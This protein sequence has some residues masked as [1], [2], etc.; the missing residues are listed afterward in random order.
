MSLASRLEGSVF[1]E[2]EICLCM[3]HFGF[4]RF[5]GR[6]PVIA[7]I[8]KFIL[9]ANISRNMH[10]EVQVYL[11]IQSKCLPLNMT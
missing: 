5:A 2:Q 4:F 1:I 9:P 3:E 11:Y 10:I 8:S 6:S 7:I